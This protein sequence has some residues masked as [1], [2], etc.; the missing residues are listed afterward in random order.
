MNSEHFD[1]NGEIGYSPEP[2]SLEGSAEILVK[3][4]STDDLLNYAHGTAVH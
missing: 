2:P 1:Q 3:R 4:P